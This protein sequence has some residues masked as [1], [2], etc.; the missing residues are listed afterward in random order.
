MVYN[1]GPQ[2]TGC[3]WTD[4]GSQRKA[5]IC[6]ISTSLQL[7]QGFSLKSYTQAAAAV[8]ASQWYTL[9]YPEQYYNQCSLYDGCSVCMK[10]N[11]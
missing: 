3:G 10:D 9:K 8:Y 7:S 5:Q 2:T 1:G 4:L 11:E 6:Y